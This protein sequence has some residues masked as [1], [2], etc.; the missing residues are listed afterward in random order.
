MPVV[1]AKFHGHDRFVVT[2]DVCQPFLLPD[3]RGNIICPE[4]DPQHFVVSEPDR[5]MVIVIGSTRVS[6]A[7][8]TGSGWTIQRVEERPSIVR[9]EM[10]PQSFAPVNHKRGLMI[11]NRNNLTSRDA[12][13]HGNPGNNE[14]PETTIKRFSSNHR[15]FLIHSAS[16]LSLARTATIWLLCL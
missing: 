2:I 6:H 3:A 5:L 12:I 10:P 9:P 1:P 4:I 7:G 16:Y 13:R 8:Q 11:G 15:G 14:G